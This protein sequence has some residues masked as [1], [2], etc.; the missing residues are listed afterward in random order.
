M[1]KFLYIPFLSISIAGCFLYQAH[2]ISHPAPLLIGTVQ[3]PLGHNHR[4]PVPV[5]YGGHIISVEMQHSG[6]M[7]FEIPK[8][9]YQTTFYVLVTQAEHICPHVAHLG[10]DEDRLSM[11]D[12][13]CVTADMPYK[14]YEL[15]LVETEKEKESDFFSDAGQD[16]PAP[17]SIAYE[18]KI[19]EMLLPDTGQIP[20]KTVIVSFLPDLVSDICGGSEL[21]LPTI[22]VKNQE[23]KED[24]S[25]GNELGDLAVQMQLASLDINTLHAPTKKIIANA[26]KCTFIIA[27][28]S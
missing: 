14:L 11:V 28:A 9:K 21:A 18:W 17:I 6:K 4:E 22:Y 1:K 26:T 27:P 5:Y 10:T 13:L 3:F 24:G 25:G 19:Q 12:Y 20:D 15:T 16:V 23:K 8:E 7:S 2:L